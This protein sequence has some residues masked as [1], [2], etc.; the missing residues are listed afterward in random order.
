MVSNDWG[1]VA[2]GDFNGD[3]RDDVLW[4]N[5]TGTISDWLATPSGGFTMGT[6]INVPTDW[7]VAGT[8]DFNGD[9]RDDILWRHLFTGQLTEW[10][11]SAEGGWIDNAA[12]ASSIVDNGW[13]IAGTGDYNDDGRADILWR[14]DDGQLSQWSSTQAGGFIAVGMATFASPDWHIEIY[15]PSPWDY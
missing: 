13:H 3:G 9:G 1:L 7:Y 14:H 15:N 10:L 12:N 4:R 5:S 11:T 6:G 2:T 8:G